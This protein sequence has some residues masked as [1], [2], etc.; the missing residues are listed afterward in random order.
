MVKVKR[1]LCLFITLIVILLLTTNCTS[2]K[3]KLEKQFKKVFVEDRTVEIKPGNQYAKSYNFEYLQNSK[4]YKLENIDDLKNIVY[5][6]ANQGWDDFTFYCAESYTTCIDDVK[7]NLVDNTVLIET[8]DNYIHP[9]NSID[10]INLYYDTS[11]KIT[12]TTKRKYTEE[13]IKQIDAKIDQ[14]IK[15]NTNP[16]N[17]I[18]DNIKALHDYII[19]NTKYD[20]EMELNGVSIYNSK[21]MNGLLDEHYAICSAYT[22]VMAV[23]LN[24]L[25]LENYKISND[26]H[27]WNVVKIEGEWYHLDLTWDDPITNTGEDVLLHDYFLITTNELRDIIEKE[28]DPERKKQHNFDLNIYSEMKLK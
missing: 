19:N 22:D 26:V 20:A 6:I 8:I 5:S 25:G 10:G 23:M 17:S 24:K 21:K 2:I 16:I 14:I 4:E 13:E 27:I 15:E 28:T 3:S 9:Y 12:I 18:K 1:Y 7:N 11:G